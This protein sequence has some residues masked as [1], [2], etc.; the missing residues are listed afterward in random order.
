M[1]SQVKTTVRILTVLAFS[2][3]LALAATYLH[4]EPNCASAEPATDL[5]WID[6]AIEAKKAWWGVEAVTM[7]PN[8]GTVT[9]SKAG[10][11]SCCEIRI[12]G[13][14][15]KRSCHQDIIQAFKLAVTRTYL[16]ENR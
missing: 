5:K 2:L 15:P 3:A 12:R 9:F 16:R 13:H 14:A 10:P 7:G 4:L 11:L 8:P 1:P 6:N